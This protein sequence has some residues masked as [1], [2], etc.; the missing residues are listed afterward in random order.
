MKVCVQVEE[1]I[2]EIYNMDR[3]V[4]S[5][6]RHICGGKISK[7]KWTLKSVKLI[8]Y[9]IQQTFIVLILYAK[10]CPSF[11]ACNSEKNQTQILL[12]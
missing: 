11:W 3:N 2:H 12:L 7:N 10:H 4:D 5:K 8:Y 1:Y 6:G 9:F